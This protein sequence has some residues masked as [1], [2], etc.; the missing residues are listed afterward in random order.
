MLVR[1]CR[2]HG[3]DVVEYHYLAGIGQG[4]D[5]SPFAVALVFLLSTIDTREVRPSLSPPTFLSPP[6][7]PILDQ[8]HFS[9][10]DA[11]VAQIRQRGLGAVCHIVTL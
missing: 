3:R 11:A 8:G 2:V 9:S 5:Y 7:R 10:R 6:S 1:L 4:P